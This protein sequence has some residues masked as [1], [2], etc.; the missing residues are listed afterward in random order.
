ML[1][2]GHDEL[3]VGLL[4]VELAHLVL[5]HAALLVCCFLNVDELLVQLVALPDNPFIFGLQRL[6]VS[7]LGADL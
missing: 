3:Q 7:A 4:A 5:E 1:V 6:L 2:L